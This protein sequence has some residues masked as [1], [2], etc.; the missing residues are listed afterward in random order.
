LGVLDAVSKGGTFGPWECKESVP[1][2]FLDGEM[3]IPDD[4]ERIENLRLD[5]ERESPLYFYSDAYANQLGLSRAHLAN[6]SW[7][8]KIKQILLT[9]KI[10]LWVVDI[11]TLRLFS[12]G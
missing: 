5:S 12:R 9:R 8:K 4:H 6:E 1:C 7:R 11:W 3:T 2:L 10:K